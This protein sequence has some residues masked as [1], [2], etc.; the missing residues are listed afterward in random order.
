MSKTSNLSFSEIL[1]LFLEMRFRAMPKNF[2]FHFFE[3]IQFD[4]IF[5]CGKRGTVVEYLIVVPKIVGS[6]PSAAA[7]EIFQL[8][9]SFLSPR[10]FDPGSS[11][12]QA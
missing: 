7:F 4:K 5:L 9:Q 11:M 3:S 1:L 2:I 10:G 6:R 12:K 8:C